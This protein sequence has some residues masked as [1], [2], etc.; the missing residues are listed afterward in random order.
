MGDACDLFN[1]IDYDNDGILND[2]DNCIVHFNPN[3]SDYDGDGFG[4]ACD[5]LTIVGI[6]GSDVLELSDDSV[7]EVSFVSIFGWREGD[8]VTVDFRTI[9]NID[10]DEDVTASR[11]GTA[12]AHSSVWEVYDFGQFVELL[13]GTLWKIAVPDQF[14][15]S[16][17]L[18]TQRVVV[19]DLH[20]LV[21]ES[22]GWIVGARLVQ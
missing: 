7:W 4:D 10:E 17:W 9:N 15:V 20:Y 16:S 21:R 14:W 12:V 3:Q 13:N 6:Y 2:F 22:D 8:R 11:L 5:P 1:D 19:V 18:R